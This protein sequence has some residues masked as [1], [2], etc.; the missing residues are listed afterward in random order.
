MEMISKSSFNEVLE[1]IKI[2]RDNTFRAINKGLID[3]YWTV[4]E[5]ISDRVTRSDWGSS[6]VK[7]LS[8]YITENEPDIRG[9]SSQNLWR[10]KQ[11]FET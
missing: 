6:T 5:Y 1:L 11:F 9:F 10:M 4:G 8:E 2:A 7:A 3:L